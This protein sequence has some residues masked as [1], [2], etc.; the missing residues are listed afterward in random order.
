[1][2]I[3]YMIPCK[4]RLYNLVK[5]LPSVLGAAACSPPVEVIVCDYNSRDATSSYVGGLDSPQL[6]L[7][8][9]TGRDYFHMA[10]A[11][12]FMARC[13]SGEWLLQG[14]T[15]VAFGDSFFVKLRA[16]IET[17]TGDYYMFGWKSWPGYTVVRR[18]DFFD[19]GGFDERLEFYGS[20]DRDLIERLW[21]RGLGARILPWREFE[22]TVIANTKDEKAAHY[23]P[24]LSQNAMV[25]H[26]IGIYRENVRRGVLVANEGVAWGA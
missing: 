19:A 6:K 24:G 20:E 21:R 12:N 26:N 1:V 14:S 13:S 10:H 25:R 16:A 15:D 18:Q 11:R 8:R 7:I 4:E 2:T 23:R 22:M 3:S 17:Q 9:Y 5:T